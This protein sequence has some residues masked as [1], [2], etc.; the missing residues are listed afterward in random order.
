MSDEEQRGY[1]DFNNGTEQLGQGWDYQQ[2][3]IDAQRDMYRRRNEEWSRAFTPAPSDSGAGVP[4]EGGLPAWLVG[5]LFFAIGILSVGTADL[6]KLLPTIIWLA[7][8][9]GT[10]AAASYGAIALVAA[11][12]SM[13]RRL[14]LW[15]FVAG[16]IVM[17]AAHIVFATFHL[18][19]AAVVLSTLQL[20]IPVGG[21]LMLVLVLAGALS[22]AALATARQ[23]G[24]R[25][26]LIAGAVVVAAATI[27]DAV[28]LANR[29]F[30]G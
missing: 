27:V 16:V 6:E 7:V 19:F 5:G 13:R 20:A 15:L 23:L 9:I 22:V 3:R 17:S 28:L 25:S 10:I 8:F 30:L 11:K 26:A 24:W 4:I 18:S 29:Y 1:Q 12:R 2:G 21:I 14:R